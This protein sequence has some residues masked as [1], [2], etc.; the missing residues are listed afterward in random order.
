MK[1]LFDWQLNLSMLDLFP[2]GGVQKKSLVWILDLIQSENKDEIEVTVVFFPQQ[3]VVKVDSDEL[4][5][6]WNFEDRAYKVMRKEDAIFVQDKKTN[7]ISV[8]SVQEFER[9]SKRRKK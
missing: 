4:L 1:F 8:V 6:C 3:F 9:N 2:V 5:L 7:L